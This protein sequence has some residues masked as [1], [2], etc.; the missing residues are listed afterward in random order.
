MTL[1]PPELKREQSAWATRI[2]T[3]CPEEILADKPLYVNQCPACYRDPATKRNCAICCLPKIALGEPDWKKV[4]GSCYKNAGFRNCV[5]CQVP[6]ISTTE[7]T[8]RT[9]CSACFK[10]QTLYRKC[11]KCGQNT[12]KPGSAPF[13]KQCGPCWLKDK[14]KTH[15]SCPECKDPRLTVKK[16]QSMCRDCMKKSGIIKTK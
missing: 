3:T 11:D 7:P 5:S 12:I 1:E 8:W 13:L 16:G 10:D 6:N 4:C 2:C 9:L 15:I 14:S